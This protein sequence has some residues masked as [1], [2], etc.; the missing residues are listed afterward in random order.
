M[1]GHAIHIHV[2]HRKASHFFTLV[3]GQFTLAFQNKAVSLSKNTV[4]T[5]FGKWNEKVS[6]MVSKINIL[7]FWDGH[8]GQW[9]SE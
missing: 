1:L 6:F 5:S 3:Y 7:I 2:E 9:H 8:E 4:A